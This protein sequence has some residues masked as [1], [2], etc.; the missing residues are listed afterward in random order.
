MIT[1]DHFT[2][3]LKH[4]IYIAAIDHPTIFDCAI[5]QMDRLKWATY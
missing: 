3:L 1:L 4:E 2:F 5:S